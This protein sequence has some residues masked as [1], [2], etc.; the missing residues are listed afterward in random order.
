MNIKWLTLSSLG[1]PP[2]PKPPIKLSFSFL[3]PLKPCMHVKLANLR[4]ISILRGE[5]CN[6][7]LW[8]R[9]ERAEHVK[10]GRT[11]R[12]DYGLPI[13][14]ILSELGELVR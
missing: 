12:V 10:T 11:R 4:G 5:I 6:L 1:P 13:F 2:F 7:G 14:W 8:S 9:L 3:I